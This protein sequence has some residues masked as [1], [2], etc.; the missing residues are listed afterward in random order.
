MSEIHT[1]IADEY[2]SLSISKR[3]RERTKES[4]RE[5]KHTL[6]HTEEAKLNGFR[7]IF[8]RRDISYNNNRRKLKSQRKKQQP[9]NTQTH[10]HAHTFIMR[11][12]E[13]TCCPT[14][15]L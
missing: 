10:T 7:T 6:A 15:P 5:S 12:N 3:A 13:L 4:E 8:I 2:Y 9:A 1:K 11:F 14:S